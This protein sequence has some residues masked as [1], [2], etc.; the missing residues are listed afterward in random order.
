MQPTGTQH[1]SVLLVVWLW[2]SCFVKV[3]VVNTRLCKWW[4]VKYGYP[5]LCHEVTIPKT[6]VLF[7]DYVH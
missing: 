4:T 7:R 1:E 5:L 6:K 3:K 2:G